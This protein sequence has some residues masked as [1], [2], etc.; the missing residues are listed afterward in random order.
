MKHSKFAILVVIILLSVA[1]FTCTNKSSTSSGGSSRASFFIYGLLGQDIDE[2]YGDWLYARVFNHPDFQN[3]SLEL[4]NSDSTTILVEED[5]WDSDKFF[6]EGNQEVNW[7]DNTTYYLTFK[8]LNQEY[9]GTITILPELEIQNCWLS[10]NSLNIE[11][12]NVGADFYNIELY[13]PG[14]FEE[15][16]Q[17]ESNAVVID[18]S[19][20][21]LDWSEELDI[22]IGG[23]KGFS[24][25]NPNSNISNCHG[26]L[27]GYSRDESELNLE[28]GALSKGTGDG[29]RDLDELMVALANNNFSMNSAKSQIRY[30]FTYAALDAS[31][32][33]FH[34]ITLI[35]PLNSI[36]EISGSINTIPL[37]FTNWGTFYYNSGYYNEIYNTYSTFLNIPFIL[38]VNNVIDTASVAVPDSFSLRNAPDDGRIPTAPFALNWRKPANSD[39]FL[40][41][42]DWNIADEPIN[43]NYI[44]ITEN[45][46]TMITPIPENSSSCF[47]TIFAIKGSNPQITTEPNLEKLNG[48]Y[49]SIRE[50]EDIIYLWDSAMEKSSVNNQ[51]KQDEIRQNIHKI[52]FNELKASIPE[53][54]GYDTEGLFKQSR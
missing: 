48:F 29:N 36:T 45:N 15:N 12:T 26:Y 3:I 4:L 2:D 16:F 37:D 46:Y 54:K 8:D 22:S 49:Y 32:E 43:K 18:L 39:F 53:L 11:W 35:D 42:V 1:L 19:M 7:L 41:M 24:I 40:V 14:E 51:H 38:S 27:F 33:D 21:A 47:I 17:S 5:Y 10:G 25:E 52:L 6:T 30:Q 50:V 13:Q 44:Y 31:W 34:S 9:S 28:T 23:F 20:L